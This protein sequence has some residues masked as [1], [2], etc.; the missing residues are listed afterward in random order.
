[1]TQVTHTP[2]AISVISTTPSRSVGLLRSSPSPI[3]P[4]L[5]ATTDLFPLFFNFCTSAIMH[6]L[7]H[8]VWLLLFNILCLRFV[9]DSCYLPVAKETKGGETGHLYPESLPSSQ[10]P[11]FTTSTIL[12]YSLCKQNGSC[13]LC[14]L[15][16]PPG[17]QET[18][19]S[20]FPFDHI[21]GAVCMITPGFHGWGWL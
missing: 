3:Q 6:Y 5:S 8:C 20:I 15:S 4:V 11:V 12:R 18:K 13:H 17:H 14:V 10:S 2:L 16:P 9:C 21:A 19:L 1:L 7:L